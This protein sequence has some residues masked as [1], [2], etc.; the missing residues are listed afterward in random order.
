MPEEATTT[1]ATVPP[2][3]ARAGRG[4]IPV[5]LLWALAALGIWAAL[6]WRIGPTE[7]VVSTPG[8][9]FPAAQLLAVGTF[10]LLTALSFGFGGGVRRRL[11]MQLRGPIARAGFDLLAGQTIVAL[12]V[13]ATATL[14]MLPWGG[15]VLLLGL[16]PLWRSVTEWRAELRN[17]RGN[18]SAIAP[19]EWAL[20][21]VAVL[22]LAVSFLSGLAPAME[23]DGVRYHLFAPQEFL[24]AGGFVHLPHHAFTNLPLQTN[25]LFLAGMT[26]ADF[27][28][29]HL[30]HWLYLPA[31]GLFAGLLA[32]AALRCLLV[33]SD[34]ALERSAALA[35]GTLTVT[36][37]VALTI[38]GWPI[39]DLSTMAFLLAGLWALLPGSIRRGDHRAIASGFLLGAAIATKLT[40]LVPAFLAGL[41]LLALA[42]NGRTF[43]LPLVAR[44]VLPMLLV[45]GPWF[46]KNVVI[47]GNPVYP[48]ATSILPSDEWP[49][50]AQELYE[51]KAAVKGFG[52]S[53]VD[54]ALLPLDVTLRWQTLHPREGLPAGRVFGVV[55]PG[56]E[57]HNP[58]PAFLALLPGALLG[59]LLLLVR[60]PRSAVAWLLAVQL[61]GGIVFWFFTYQ[62]VRF[63]LLPMALCNAL[64][65]ACLYSLASSSRGLRTAVGACA[66]LLC[67]AGAGWHASYTLSA[68]PR[69]PVAAGIGLIPGD[70]YLSTALNYY[71]AVDLLNRTVQPGERVLFIGEHRGTYAEFDVELSDWFDVPLILSEFR[72]TNSNREMVEA[73]RARGIRY[74]LWNYA[75][76]MLYL[77]S[78]F[79]PRA[80]DA[81][82]ERF[83][84]LNDALLRPRHSIFT[85]GQSP[86]QVH[87]IDLNLIADEAFESTP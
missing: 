28:V 43:S 87:V 54:F 24:K 12:L 50:E 35:A 29:A 62:S 84:A 7:P 69:R 60:R 18:R 75:E 11:G 81:E 19:L 57:D 79:R 34:A 70:V 48:A 3:A 74:V 59:A 72:R 32:R 16:I 76:M 82:W 44:F 85:S 37:P 27:R 77:Q 40:A 68:H 17:T 22:G 56:F 61:L 41:I 1:D 2:L 9:Q 14:R 86:L 6:G 64:G 51:S 65:V 30:V 8:W 55:S 21:G 20:L 4:V 63:F 42:W 67:I 45:A 13:F 83:V 26:V 38:G 23:S 49:P 71:D 47:H 73:W 25:L 58:G 36:L 80:S 15:A 53:P 5:L 33:R 46:A 39:V 52:T 10:V 78:D 31:A 66:L